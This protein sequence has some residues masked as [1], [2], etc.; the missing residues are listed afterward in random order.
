MWHALN[1]RKSKKPERDL[2]RWIESIPDDP[3]SVLD[4][5][6]NQSYRPT[7]ATPLVF[8]LYGHSHC[9][10]SLVVSDDDYME[11]LI[12]VS[13]YKNLIPSRIERAMSGAA[14]LLL[15]YRLDDWDF[16]VLFHILTGFKGVGMTH[17]AVQLAPAEN[18]SASALE[19]RVMRHLEVYQ[20]YV[21]K[22]FQ[23]KKTTIRVVPQ[24]CQ[25]FVSELGD[26]W[27]RSRHA[28]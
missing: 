2:C 11:F 26:R 1:T 4:S 20:S 14:L 8:H 6:R 17:F 24:T 7:A 23:S 12:N 3:P 18:E 22:Y 13:K 16:R 9:L 10:E 15:G 5:S 28:D 27:R 25:E 21:G 19:E